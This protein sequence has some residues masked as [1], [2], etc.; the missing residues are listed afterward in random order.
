MRDGRRLDQGRLGIRTGADLLDP[1]IGEFE[2]FRRFLLAV[3]QPGGQAVDPGVATDSKL[4][5]LGLG[6][7][8]SWV[9]CVIL[10]IV[11]G[12]VH[13]CEFLGSPPRG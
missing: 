9:R 2:H 5:G 6:S 11:F 3:R 1:A 8:G 10:G 13:G 7:G 4:S 12:G